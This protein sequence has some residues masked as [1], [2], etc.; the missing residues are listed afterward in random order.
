MKRLIETKLVN[1]LLEQYGV[2]SYK[3]VGSA[4]MD[5]V[6][7]IPEPVVI[8]GRQHRLIGA[9]LAINIQDPGLVAVVASR[10]GLYLNHRI[11]VGQGVGII[12]SDYHG[13]IGVILHNDGDEAY[14]VKWPSRSSAWPR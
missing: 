4:G 1:P 5:L 14:E 13:E 8:G 3:T 10:S 2:P 6:A 7:C 9:G 11:R 12:D